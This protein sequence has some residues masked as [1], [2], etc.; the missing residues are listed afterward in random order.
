M[1]VTSG[2]RTAV[3]PRSDRHRLERPQLRLR[4][5]HVDVGQG[6][7]RR[8]QRALLGEAHGLLDGL[9]RPAVDGVQL[10]LA[11]ELLP[12]DGLAE[13]LEAVAGAIELFFRLGSVLDGVA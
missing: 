8:R 11:R 10:G 5:A 9:L 7:S 6:L 13:A 3:R 2:G 1:A 12:E 4:E